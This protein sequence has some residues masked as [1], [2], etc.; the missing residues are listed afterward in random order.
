[1]A[2]RFAADISDNSE[3]GTQTIRLRYDAESPAESV[4]AEIAPFYGSNLCKY[5]VG[6]YDLIVCDAAL[7]KDRDW[8]GTFVLWPIPNRVR[9]KQYE[10]AGHIQSLKKVKRKRGNE[11]LIH[12]FVDDIPWQFSEPEVDA[13]SARVRTWVEVKRGDAIYEYY[14]YESRLELT[15]TLTASGIKV[16]YEVQNLGDKTLPFGFALHPYFAA[17]SGHDETL[18]VLPAEHIMEADEDLLPSGTL[19]PMGVHD[20][21]LRNP[22]PVSSLEL[23][24]VFTGLHKDADAAIIYPDRHLK[25]KLACSSEFTH[26]V[27]YTLESDKGFI[28][29]ENQT[30]S[31]DMINLHTKSQ[32]ESDEDLAKAAHL[33]TLPAGESHSGYIEYRIEALH[34]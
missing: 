25:L 14:P 13:Q 3:L 34:Q 8:T 29:F 1:M 33:M 9:D 12:G 24:H 27:L 16:A 15:Y 22:T 6:G 2:Q 7:L 28:C 26:M 11:P 20:Y 19:L 30:G 18:V 17:H 32:K 4:Y 10:F 23:D 31:T 5:Q 21:D